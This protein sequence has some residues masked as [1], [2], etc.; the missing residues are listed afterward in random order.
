MMQFSVPL[1]T[2]RGVRL[3]VIIK[4]VHARKTFHIKAEKISV[5][6][7]KQKMLK[8]YCIL[9]LFSIAVMAKEELKQQNSNKFIPTNEWQTIPEGLF[10][11][12][13]IVCCI[14]L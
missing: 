5:Q 4:K 3:R 2:S 14:I 6:L 13:K 8:G 11:N 10:Y 7:F 12:N 1:S 9:I